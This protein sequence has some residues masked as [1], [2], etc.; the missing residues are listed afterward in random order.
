MLIYSYVGIN[1]KYYLNNFEGYKMA[2]NYE[3]C[4]LKTPFTLLKGFV[5]G[6]NHKASNGFKYFFNRKSGIRRQTFGE[7]FK[8]LFDLDQYSY[9]CI[10][11][12]HVDEF[13]EAYLSIK[14]IGAELIERGDIVSAE[15]SI[16]LCIYSKSQSSEFEKLLENKDESL[17]LSQPKAVEQ[18][19][20]TGSTKYHDYI[21]KM[22]SSV[23][24]PFNQVMGFYLA[25]KK[26][27]F[28]EFVECTDIKLVTSS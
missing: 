23:S 16:D 5:L 22:N 1:T 4:V 20:D 14:G 15:F 17:I 27:N 24:G 11:K 19:S 21:Y 18:I 12:D 7:Y 10:D 13:L 8:E 3:Q 28:S 26:S 6:Y 2:T 9:I 25:I